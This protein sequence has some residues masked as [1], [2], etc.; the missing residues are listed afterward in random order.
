MKK[1]LSKDL[2]SSES[3]IYNLQNLANSIQISLQERNS[4]R[5][6]YL[7][8]MVEKAMYKAYFFNKDDLAE[9]LRK[10]ARMNAVSYG[11][12]KSLEC[13]LDDGDITEDEYEFCING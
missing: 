9:R 1:H 2:Y 8:V 7:T 3:E 5:E 12:F 11:I 10:Q 13:M 4:F 6:M